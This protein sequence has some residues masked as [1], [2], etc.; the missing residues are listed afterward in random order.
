MS[1][2][3]LPLFLLAACASGRTQP[4]PS[5]VPGADPAPAMH[6]GPHEVVLNGARHYYRIG[7]SARWP[8]WY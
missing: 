2:R 5:V 6:P 7:G 1:L 8:G 4:N 3:V